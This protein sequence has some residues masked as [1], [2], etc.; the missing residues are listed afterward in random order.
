MSISTDIKKA[1]KDKKMVIGSRSV[2]KSLKI[3]KTTSVIYATN[4]PKPREV[5]RSRS[6]CFSAV[7]TQSVWLYIL[8]RV[9]WASASPEE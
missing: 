2:V 6:L 5:I 3:G 1:M 4:L 8:V 9:S 7:V